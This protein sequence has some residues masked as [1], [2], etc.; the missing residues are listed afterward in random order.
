MIPKTNLYK[1]SHVT[2]AH[3]RADIE[4]LLEKFTVR[5]FA[6]KRDDPESSML[7]FQRNE[8]FTGKEREVTYKITILYVER[9]Q[10]KYKDAI[11]DE[12]RSYRILFHI[13]KAML[14]NTDVGMEF[15]QVFGN[16]II[17][18]QLPNGDPINVQDRIAS[19]LSDDKILKL[20]FIEDVQTN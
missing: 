8:Q 17:V 16:Y 14:L 1:T 4:E 3:S 11:Y 6:W 19:A 20:E 15:E 12:V 10:G 13:L 7:L 2:P 9:S 5:K 18:G